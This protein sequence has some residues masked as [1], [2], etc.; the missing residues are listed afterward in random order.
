MISSH[1]S[2]QGQVNLRLPSVLF[3]KQ[4]K[5]GQ[6]SVMIILSDCKFYFLINIL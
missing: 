1:Y 6:G 2:S 3:G 5:N 4:N